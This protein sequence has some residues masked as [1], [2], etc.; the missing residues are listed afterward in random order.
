MNPQIEQLKSCYL[1]DNLDESELELICKQFT[2]REF[3]ANDVLIQ[4]NDKS[5]CTYVLLE[6]TVRIEIQSADGER[7]EEITKLKANDIVGEFIL[8][9]N[10]RR[11]A[12]ITAVTDLKTCESNRDSLIRLFDKNPKIGY[13]VYKNLSEI[14]V[15]RIKGTNM[16]ARNALGLSIRMI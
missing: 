3:E 5:D 8:A 7:Q 14:L 15:D 1:F 9:R 16:A 10:A 12:T 13:L 2:L 6:G 4:E 11:S